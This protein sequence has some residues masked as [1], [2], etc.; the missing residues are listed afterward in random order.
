MTVKSPYIIRQ[1]CVIDNGRRMRGLIPTLKK[2]F[3]PLYKFKN[4]TIEPD[5][6][7]KPAIFES[8]NRGLGIRVDRELSSRLSYDKCHPITRRV[9]DFLKKHNYQI[10]ETQIPV[11]NPDWRCGTSIDLA[12]TDCDNEIVLLEIK[13][14]Y[15][16][17]KFRHTG[18]KM[19]YPFEYFTDCAYNQHRLQLFFGLK[20]WNLTFPSAQCNKAILLYVGREQETSNILNLGCFNPHYAGAVE[21]LSQKEILKWP[22]RRPGKSYSI[23][24]DMS[25]NSPGIACVSQDKT[26]II[27][28]FIPQRVREKG[29]CVRTADFMARALVKKA[30][31]KNK[32]A[33]R[34]VNTAEAVA[35][36]V[37]ELYRYYQVKGPV[38]IEGFA[39]AVGTGKSAATLLCVL[40]NQGKQLLRCSCKVIISAPAH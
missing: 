27:S 1:G 30:I 14:G 36:C 2:N 3:Y 9:L 8:S 38:K 13:T 29:M 32:T 10:L 5:N 39:Y 21:V 16:S 11:C 7:Q 15:T 24:I 25:L 26:H 34:M 6:I 31:P 35:N 17:Y 20:M 12:A 4:A 40:R 28:A 33:R 22:C 37:F 19:H 23:G 18:S